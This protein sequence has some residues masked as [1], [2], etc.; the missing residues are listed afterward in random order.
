MRAFLFAHLCILLAPAPT[1]GAEPPVGFFL[2]READSDDKLRLLQKKETELLREKTGAAP[3]KS[4]DI[5]R[6]IADLRREMREMAEEMRADAEQSLQDAEARARESIQGAMDQAKESI[7]DAE[8]RVREAKAQVRDAEARAR[9]LAQENRG[10]TIDLTKETGALDAALVAARRLRMQGKHDEAAKLYQK[11]IA[12]NQDSLGSPR[13]YEARFWLAKCKLAGQKW[14]EAGEAFTDFLKRHSDQR[15]YSQQAKEDRIYCWKMR[16]GQNPKAV[17]GL[18]AALKDPDANIRVQAALALAEGKDASG[19]AALEESLGHPRLGEQ[20]GLA[21]WKLGLRDKP[22]AGEAPAPWAKMLVVKVKCPDPDDSF[23][24]R[25]PINFV[26][27][28]VKMLP[29]DATREMERKGVGNIV[30]MA[31]SAPKGQVLFQFKSDG[32]KT[33]VVISVE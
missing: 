7:R 12:D 13:L 9:E 23:E 22:K 27:D 28:V 3:E 1:H 10:L 6:E 30:D 26:K 19:R 29:E 31:A 4:K 24:M 14:D 2:R 16:L 18:R 21:L 8:A 32:G 33:S 25:V 20:C 15:T 17:L 5:D 11:F